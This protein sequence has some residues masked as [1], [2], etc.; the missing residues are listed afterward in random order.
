MA[1]D[2]FLKLTGIDGESRDLF[3]PNEI[4]IADLSWGEQNGTLPGPFLTGLATAQNIRF[5]KRVDRASVAL[6]LAC[7][8]GRSINQAVIS[9]RQ[10]GGE[11]TFDFLILTLE[12]CI[13]ASYQVFAGSDL[14]RPE[15]H[16]SLA[17]GV[18]NASYR[19]TRPD[20]SAGGT[21][22]A[23]YDFIRR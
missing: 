1:I 13:V 17:F 4:E 6:M 5:V 21:I 18:I 2:I 22:S 20:G 8:N 9:V 12:R 15:E 14:D 3:H 11:N 7:A 16:V 23:S 10:S 19:P